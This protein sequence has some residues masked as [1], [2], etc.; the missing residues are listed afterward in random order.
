M[1]CFIGQLFFSLIDSHLKEARH[2]WF[3]AVILAT[4]EV[5]I[6][7]MKVWNHP[8]ANSSQDP[9]SK[10]PNTHKKGLVE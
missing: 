4:W 10:I 5:E 3:T 1:F 6:R 2:R 7:R 9:I 8:W